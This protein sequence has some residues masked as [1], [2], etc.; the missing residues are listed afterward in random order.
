MV[1]TTSR[2]CIKAYPALFALARSFAQ[3]ERKITEFARLLV[4]VGLLHGC[5]VD[6]VCVWWWPVCALE[7]TLVMARPSWAAGSRR[8]LG[9][10][11]GRVAPASATLPACVCATALAPCADAQCCAMR[12]HAANPGPHTALCPSALQPLPA[13]TAHSPLHRR[14]PLA[15]MLQPK[16]PPLSLLP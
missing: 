12:V 9:Q 7:C 6:V 3:S 8:R 14:P 11:W 16:C 10:M 5:G 4:E 1:G 15:V 2:P 13:A